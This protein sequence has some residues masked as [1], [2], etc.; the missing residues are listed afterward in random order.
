MIVIFSNEKL[1]KIHKF[2]FLMT[3]FL[4]KK[5]AA[6]ILQERFRSFRLRLEFL[7]QRRAAVVLQVKIKVMVS[8]SCIP[9]LNPLYFDIQLYVFIIAEAM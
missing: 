1:N 2:V 4:A 5:Q 7:R 8:F 6:L 9:E 3:A